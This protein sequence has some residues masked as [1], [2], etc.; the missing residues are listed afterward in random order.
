[1]YLLEVSRMQSFKM[2]FLLVKSKLEE[3]HM[4]WNLMKS[5]HLKVEVIVYLKISVIIWEKW[6]SDMY[7]IPILKENG[8]LY[9]FYL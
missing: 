5:I 3:K 1:M 7:V 4:Q 9:N 8:V 6:L 2:A